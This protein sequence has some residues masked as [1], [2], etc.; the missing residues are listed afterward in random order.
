MRIA[1]I[2]DIHANLP[3]L[4][5]VLADIKLQS[6][7]LTVNLGDHLAGPIDPV[8]VADLLME[9][10]FPTIRGNHDRWLLE[11]PGGELTGVDRFVADRLTQEH[12]WWLR[13]QPPTMALPDVFMCHGTP[14]SDE[15]PWLDH[16]WTGR[17][18]PQPDEAEVAALAEGLDYPV[19]VC[20]HT[21]IPR[22]VR[23]KDG[24]LI[25]NPGS[26]GL[27][28]NHGTPDAQYAI[29]DRVGGDWRAQQRLVPYDREAAASAAE[30]NGFPRWRAALIT[31]WE[32][33]D[34]LF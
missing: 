6:P 7:D 30:A 13:T 1:V 21:H 19:L 3:A 34:G 32:T 18:H 27:Q 5:A 29:L 2:S 15:S 23:L 10:D 28:I 11:P 8:A 26:V 22:A 16:W 20:G 31:G 17:M 25:V 9:G 4:R 24:R 33:P 12:Y 14:Q